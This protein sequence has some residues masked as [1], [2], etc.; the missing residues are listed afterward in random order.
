MRFQ[1]IFGRTLRD[2]P[3]DA[4][5]VSHQ[6]AVRAGLV[7]PLTGGIYAWLPLGLRVLH[8]V[9]AILREEMEA[10]GAQEVM[11]PVVHPAEVWQQTGRWQQGFDGELLKF[12]NRDGR[13]YVLGA[14]AEDVVASVAA[15][16]IDSHRDL[17]QLIYQI[18]T[19]YR[20]TARPRGGLVR[21]REFMM[22][23]AYSLD[24][25]RAGLE[26]TYGRLFAAYQ[27]IFRRVGLDVIPL[28][29]DVGSMGGLGGQEFSML[30][31]AGE[32]RLVYCPNCGYAANMDVAEF[33]PAELV[34]TE[35]AAV[36]KVATPDCKT[37]EDV[38]HFLGVAT[39][40]TAKAV[41][42]MHENAHNDADFVFVVV[43]GD[44]EVNEVKLLRAL[45]GGTLRAAE[46]DEIRAVGAEPGYASPVGLTARARLADDAGVI[47]VADRSI[48]NSVNLVSGANEAGYHLTGVNYP[49]DFTVTLL[50]DIAEAT[51]G[52]ACARCADGTL[53]IERA[54]ELGHCFKLGTYYSE[55]MGVT[56]LNEHGKAQPVYMGSYGIGLDRLI[57]AIIEMHHD[58]YGIVWPRC[59]A[60]FDVHIVTLGKQVE[61]QARGQALYEELQQAGLSVLLDDR[62]E[63][64]GVKFTD[65]DLIGAP[66]R[67]TI[68]QRAAERGAVE[69]KWR[70][71]GDRFD[72]PLENTVA[73]VLDLWQA[74]G[75]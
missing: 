22:K 68:S 45:G 46:E 29:A 2:A 33:I 36:A 40:Q 61:Y 37:I 31:E 57:A 15:R 6:L 63:R 52:A 53:Q 26:Q 62:Q 56:Y 72:I 3:T 4:E 66:L 38:A 12:Q 71:E 34:A 39:R 27:N 69:A 50:A 41:F 67:L 35:A 19:K 48:E 43:R 11:M 51:Q 23:D 59:V 20:D 64:P 24:H 47:V 32:D 70:H 44:L 54:I 30:H 13:N 55:K 10:A 49:R 17:P 9:A 8:K 18:Q 65:A 25:D 7:R 75:G 16:E 60:P 28:D 5:L 42:F 58:D 21:L 1:D 74:T 14:T 73:A